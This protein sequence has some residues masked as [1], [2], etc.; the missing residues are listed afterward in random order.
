MIETTRKL[1]FDWLPCSQRE[2]RLSVSLSSWE[3]LRGAVAVLALLPECSVQSGC[4]S[5]SIFTAAAPETRPRERHGSMQ[6]AGPV[7]AYAEPPLGDRS[8]GPATQICFFD[9][10]GAFST[11]THRLRLQLLEVAR[12]RF[13]FRMVRGSVGAVPRS[14]VCISLARCSAWAAVRLLQRVLPDAVRF[15]TRLFTVEAKQEIAKLCH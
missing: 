4:P 6:A 13:S 5:A 7:S 10:N 3:G 1:F 14:T 9:I 2:V 12:V 8:C 15:L 11:G